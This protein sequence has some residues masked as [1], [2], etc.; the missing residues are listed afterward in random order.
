M[1]GQAISHIS[2]TRTSVWWS[3]L[4]V[5]G[6]EQSCTQVQSRAL[7]RHL[8]YQ[9]PKATKVDLRVELISVN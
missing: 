5:S 7:L 2:A 1:H 4:H 8:A 3:P 9:S 6:R